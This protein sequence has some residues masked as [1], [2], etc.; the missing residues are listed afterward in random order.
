MATTTQASFL[1]PVSFAERLA[2]E[3]EI[4][5]PATLDEYLE[6]AEQAE[7]KIEYSL[8]HIVSM[9]QA[10]DA[11][12]LI[13]PNIATILNNLFAD[14]PEFRVYGSNLGVFIPK[15]E[16]HYKPDV[17]VLRTAPQFKRHKVK[18]KTYKSVLNP[19]AVF[20]VYSDSTKEYDVSEKLPNYKQC[21]SLRYIVFVHQNK[22]LAT[23]YS[24]P[25]EKNVWQEQQLEGLDSSFAFEGQIVSLKNVYKRVVFS[26]YNGKQKIK[27]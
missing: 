1:L 10:T 7:Y 14:D 4:R 12:E 9:G 23:V 13:C 25:D 22:P 16:A 11:H 27:V 24:R 18:S 17:S 8:G 26:G 21:E 6:F 20:E 5:I 19:L 15:T 2:L 3:D